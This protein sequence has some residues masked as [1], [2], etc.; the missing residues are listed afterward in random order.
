MQ[1]RPYMLSFDE[2]RGC[3]H[4]ALNTVQAGENKAKCGHCARPPPFADWHQQRARQGIHIHAHV[5]SSWYIPLDTAI[6]SFPLGSCSQ[7]PATGL[8]PVARSST[9]RQQGAYPFKPLAHFPAARTKL[10]ICKSN[11]HRTPRR[12]PAKAKGQVCVL[13]AAA[14]QHATMAAPREIKANPQ[15]K[16]TL[17]VQE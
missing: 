17:M 14:A 3:G 15:K 9:Q 1:A 11:S 7:G 2:Q 12:M 16:T 5:H 8:R 13:R 4:P 10:A 6:S